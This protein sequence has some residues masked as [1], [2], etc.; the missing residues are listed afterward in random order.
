[1]LRFYRSNNQEYLLKEL[2]KILYQPSENPLLPDSII[3]RNYGMKNWIEKQFLKN[4]GISANL[5]FIFP[6]QFL[7]SILLFNQD[8]VLL[9]VKEWHWKILEILYKKLATNLNKLLFS[10]L[11][12]NHKKE[13]YFFAQHLAE[14]F[15]E[16][17]LF[18]PKIFEEEIKSEHY[19]FQKEIWQE[20]FIKQKYNSLFSLFTKKQNFINNLPYRIF[21]FGISYMPQVY[22]EIF[23]ELAKKIDVHFFYKNSGKEYFGGLLNPKQ[24]IKKKIYH[25]QKELKDLNYTKGHSLLSFAKKESDFQYFLLE[26]DWENNIVAEEY[27]CSPK[28]TLLAKI[29][30]DMQSLTASAKEE[31]WQKYKEGTTRLE[32]IRIQQCHNKKREVEELHRYLLRLLEENTELEPEDILVKSPVISEYAL[33]IE[34]VFLYSENP[35]PYS[36]ADY[37]T[38]LPGW[39]ENF[40]NLPNIFKENYPK[41][42]IFDFFCCPQVFKKF[43]IEKEQLIILK[44][45]F[46]QANWRWG[47]DFASIQKVEPL[48]KENFSA[49]QAKEKILEAFLTTSEIEV[50]EQAYE[51]VGNFL[52]FLD[53]IFSLNDEHGAFRLQS[54]T[55]WTKSITFVLEELFYFSSSEQVFVLEIKERLHEV[56]SFCQTKD[57]L[58][59]SDVIFCFL[60]NFSKEIFSKKRQ[61]NFL[62][63]GI[64]FCNIQPMRSIPFEVICFLGLQEETFPRKQ[65]ASAL[66]ILHNLQKENKLSLPKQLNLSSKKDED[67][68]IFWE[69]ILSAKSFF[70]ISFVGWDKEGKMQIPSL[71]LV[72]LLQFF[73]NKFQIKSYEEL[74]FFYKHYLYI[75]DDRYFQKESLHKNYES[76]HYQLATKKKT[77][78]SITTPALFNPVDVPRHITIE[79]LCGFFKSP[80]KYFMDISCKIHFFQKEESPNKYDFYNWEPLKSYKFAEN[81]LSQKKQQKSDEEILE[82]LAYYQDFPPLQILKKNWDS[83]KEFLKNWQMEIDNLIETSFQYFSY[84]QEIEGIVVFGGETVYQNKFLQI[85]PSSFKAKRKQ[86]F[87][88]RHLFLCYALAEKEPKSYWVGKG[89]NNNAEVYMLDFVPDAKKYLFYIMIVYQ[90]GLQAPL[91]LHEK[92]FDI[93]D[94]KKEKNLEPASYQHLEKYYWDLCFLNQD[95]QAEVESLCQKIIAPMNDFLH[96]KKNS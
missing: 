86:E 39:L 46:Q 57:Y 59:D 77:S 73:C 74:P 79:D 8:K 90:K 48:T 40:F 6:N 42:E 21:I 53:L 43:S 93:Y 69:S 85:A 31:N 94:P 88:I 92:T 25:Q 54:F 27:F 45:L 16:Y 75:F 9:D 37:D 60:K 80:L 66:N 71:A 5:S 96:L 1:M 28:Q 36:I 91:P 12:K 65:N 72:M 20:I 81:W 64:S 10:Y 83:N 30:K 50:E 95:V 19:I 82:N 44:N 15:E 63:N 35:I 38:T 13:I 32:T 2:Q 56:A 4:K 41:E 76:Y 89:E 22:L 49:K 84:S 70:Y 62:K 67:F 29:Q 33:Y 78:S 23:S 26:Q 58:I 55:E 51:A 68:Y 47:K 87:W 7:K 34:E 18:Y 17:S 52:Q 24:E 14:I 11:Q 61:S 3:I